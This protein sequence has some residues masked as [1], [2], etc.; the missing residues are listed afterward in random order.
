MK[1]VIFDPYGKKFTD[2]MIKWWQEHGHEVKYDRYYDPKIIEWADVIWFDTTDNNIK[3][4]TNP[5]EALID[6]QKALGMEWDMHKMDLTGKKVICRPIDIEVWLGH[7]NGVDWNLVTDVIFLANHIKD[8]MLKDIPNPP[9]KIYTI[10]TGVD[11]S[12]YSF[13]ERGKG[14][15]I[16]IVSEKWTS[17]GTD[18][19]LQVALSLK[20]IN[21]NYT[22]HWLGRWS[23]SEWEKAYFMEFIA[24]HGLNFNFTEWIEGDDAVDKFLEDKNYLLHASHKEAFSYATAEA[25]A[26][27]IKP[28]IHRFYGADDIWPGLTWDSIDE[29][30][31]MITDE[32]Y[33]SKGYRQYLID[34]GYT[35]DQMMDK[36]M[37]V[38][39]G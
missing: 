18:L 17:K 39:N 22:F 20:E 38:I 36:I 19:I 15:D 8:L 30:V 26:K 12:R 28:V 21:P 13:K 35:L 14:L 5:S 1:I 6:E 32:D 9:F 34:H 16:A 24:H 4:G 2:G 10:Q 7:H 3:S 25:M 37:E 33:G 11:L 27:G 31:E 23:D 29:A